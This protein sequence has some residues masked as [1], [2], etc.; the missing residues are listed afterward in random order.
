MV[1]LSR[2]VAHQ[3]RFFATLRMTAQ[4]KNRRGIPRLAEQLATLA[5]SQTP[6]LRPHRARLRFGMTAQNEWSDKMWRR[7][8]GG[9]KSAATKS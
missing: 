7:A 1:R 5:G 2:D 4:N 6:F 8:D 9:L 3:E